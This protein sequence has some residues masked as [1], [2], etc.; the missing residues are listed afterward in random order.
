ME[1]IQI[2]KAN[3][4]INQVNVWVSFPDLVD[5]DLLRPTHGLEPHPQ[6]TPRIFRSAHEC[7]AWKDP[8]VTLH[9][10]AYM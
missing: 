5:S 4:N 8:K 6:T 2:R 9:V 7:I 3:P 10:C 1:A